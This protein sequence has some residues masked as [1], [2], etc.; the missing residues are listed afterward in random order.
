MAYES[1][2]RGR[3]TLKWM[4]R[5]WL[6]AGATYT[7]LIGGAN[8]GWRSRFANAA[9]GLGRIFAGSLLVVVTAAT[10]GR[11]DF[12]AVARSIATVCRGV[13]MLVAAFGVSYQE[14]GRDYRRDK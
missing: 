11:R 10:R 5:R 4:M 9:R 8:V 6:R 1:I 13:G 2:P 3:A 14:Y 7:L 12:A